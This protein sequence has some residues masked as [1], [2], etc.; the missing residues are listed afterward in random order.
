MKPIP[1]NGPTV[2]DWQKELQS[3]KRDAHP[4]ARTLTEEQKEILI[5]A[6]DVAGIQW[7][8]IAG[9]W[10]KKFGWGC[11]GSL[12]VKYRAAKAERGE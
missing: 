10:R 4:N 7:D 8:D 12:L 6:R 5:H 9:W 11:R 2:A 1:E 3:L